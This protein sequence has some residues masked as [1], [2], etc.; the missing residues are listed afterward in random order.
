MEH[1]VRIIE[2]VFEQWEAAKEKAA[3]K[4]NKENNQTRK[5]N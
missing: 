3:E 2:R 1:I 5:D 4:D